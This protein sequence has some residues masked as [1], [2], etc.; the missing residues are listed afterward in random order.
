MK[1]FSYQW[2]IKATELY[3]P[4]AAWHPAVDCWRTKLGACKAAEAWVI[5]MSQQDVNIDFQLVE[6]VDD[7][8]NGRKPMVVR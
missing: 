6:L 2:R 7:G 4:N 3:N 1:L 8:N 5:E